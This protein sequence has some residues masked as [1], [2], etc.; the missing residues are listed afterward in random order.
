[1]ERYLYF[2]DSPTPNGNSDLSLYPTSMVNCI[3]A[4]SATTTTINFKPR[5][6][7]GDGP[8]DT[9]V[10]THGEGGCKAVISDLVAIINAERNNNPFAV[11]FDKANGISNLSG[12]T[13]I[14]INSA[15][16]P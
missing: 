7:D 8:E 13:A 15:D 10:L 9:I 4:A 14:Q 1:M 11:V 2:T 5:D 16:T 3:F 6:N 12:V